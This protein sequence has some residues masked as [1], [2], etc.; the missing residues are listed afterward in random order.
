MLWGVPV[1]MV[2]Q[3]FG[4]KPFFILA[5]NYLSRNVNALL[6]AC[7][8]NFYSL[9]I[10]FAIYMC[11][12]GMGGFI[13]TILSWKYFKPFSRLSLSLYLVHPIFQTTVTVAQK[14]PMELNQLNSVSFTMPWK[15]W[16]ITFVTFFIS[17]LFFRYWFVRDICVVNIL[18][19]AGWSA[20]HWDGKIFSRDAQ[21]KNS[22]ASGTIGYQDLIIIIEIGFH[23][24]LMK[25]KIF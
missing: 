10:A 18:I 12:M 6:I 7:F 5:G 8:R 24:S 15:D 13:N 3:S 17:A 1:I 19:F 2:G 11:H 9:G 4:A 16:L 22:K 14:H 23:K 21:Q 25:I 20:V